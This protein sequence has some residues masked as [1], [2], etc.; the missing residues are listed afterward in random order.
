MSDSSYIMIRKINL[1]VSRRADEV[2]K[3]VDTVVPE[4][5]ITLDTRFFSQDVVVLTLEVAN[6]FLEAV[7]IC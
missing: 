3:G 4:A 2:E 7:H 1:P 6:Y 5:G